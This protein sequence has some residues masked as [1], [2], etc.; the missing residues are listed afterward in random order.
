MFWFL[1]A[2]PVAAALAGA[3]GAPLLGGPLALGGPLGGARGGPRGAL[4]PAARP[5]AL[6]D[7]VMPC[8]PADAKLMSRS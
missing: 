2:E 5:S 1:D 7:F 4:A 6:E 3:R 8:N